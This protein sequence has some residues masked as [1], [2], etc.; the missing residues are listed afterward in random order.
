MII[1]PPLDSVR[2]NGKI[3][4]Y[5][6]PEHEIQISRT[7]FPSMTER[8]WVEKITLTNTGDNSKQIQIGAKEYVHNEPGMHG[9]YTIRIHSDANAT[10]NI[11]PGESYSY[12]VYYSATMNEEPLVTETFAIAEAK[13]DQ[14]LAEMQQKLVLKDARS[15]NQYTLLFLQDQ[16]S[17]KYLRYQNGAG[18]FSRW[19]QLLRRGV[20]QRPGRIFGPF[21]PIPGL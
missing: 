15:G 5:H 14:F 19:G 12:G 6:K 8:L 17:R 10:V 11:A 21:L 1:D 4:F 9:Q 3:S 13:R 20:G 2:I 16:G 18:A 7:F